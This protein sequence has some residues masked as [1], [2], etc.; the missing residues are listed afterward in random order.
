MSNENK[1]PSVRNSENPLDRGMAR[2]EQVLLVG[3][4]PALTNETRGMS[5]DE[6]ARAERARSGNPFLNSP[7]AAYFLRMSNRQM[8]RLRSRGDGPRFRRHGRYILY[9]IDDLD[10]WSKSTRTPSGGD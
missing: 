5:D 4:S 9:H 3:H 1:S 7:Q 8:E 6:D 2:G 10:A